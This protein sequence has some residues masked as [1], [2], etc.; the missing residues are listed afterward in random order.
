MTANV[1]A[2]HFVAADAGDLAEM[3]G[4]QTGDEIDKFPRCSWELGPEAVPVISRLDHWFAG[5]I[6]RRLDRPGTAGEPLRLGDALLGRGVFGATSSAAR[7]VVMPTR[8]SS[9]A[10]RIRAR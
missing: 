3:F 5:R 8:S 7:L 9:A 1:L 2:V 6:C 10:P 4:G